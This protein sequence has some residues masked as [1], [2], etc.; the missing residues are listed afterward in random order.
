MPLQAV[1]NPSTK[2]EAN[3]LADQL[4]IFAKLDENL[5]AVNQHCQETRRGFV[6]L[7]DQL[8]VNSER[9]QAMEQDNH[10]LWA[11][12]ALR[13]RTASEFEEE[14]ASISADTSGTLLDC[15]TTVHC[16]PYAPSLLP[17]CLEHEP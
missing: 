8:A 9:L 15:C 13:K 5:A 3:C 14:E 4:H 2:V 11:A 1:P 7:S 16:R 12:L 6:G 17:H 10:R